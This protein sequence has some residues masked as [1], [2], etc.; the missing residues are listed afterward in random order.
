MRRLAWTRQWAFAVV[1]AITG[2]AGTACAAGAAPGQPD[3]VVAEASRVADRAGHA[4]AFIP[5]YDDSEL[6]AVACTSRANCMVVGG[7]SAPAGAV[8]FAKRWNGRAWIQLSTPSQPIDYYG[9][10]SPLASVSCPS[11]SFCQAVGE[12]GAEGW[13]GRAWLRERTATSYRG[14]E[15][16]SVSCASATSCV[17][18]GLRSGRTAGL[19]TFAETWD[20]RSWTV[21]DPANP[22]G[23]RDDMLNSV[24]CAS[25]SD[26]VAVGQ[27]GAPRTLAEYWNGRTWRLLAIPTVAATET[28][29]SA[30]SCSSATSCLAVGRAGLHGLAESWNGSRWRLLPQPSGSPA[31]VS[32][33]AATS[34]V[35]VGATGT[36]TTA[37][38]AWNGSSWRPLPMPRFSG[39]LAGVSCVSS[40]SCMAAGSVLPGPSRTGEGEPVGD[41]VQDGVGEL[42]MRWDGQSWRALFVDPADSLRGVSCLG[43][44]QCVAV[45][46]YLTRSVTAAT[47]SAWWN[48]SSWRRQA[49][50]A[51]APGSLADVSCTSADRCVAVGSGGEP[52]V[53]RFALAEQW[54]GRS[55]RAAPMASLGR[56][57]SESAVSC[58]GTSCLAV[59]DGLLTELWN[60]ARWKVVTARRPPHFAAGDL[61]D[62]SCASTTFCMATGWFYPGAEADPAPFAESWNGTR[63]TLLSAPAVM[64]GAVSC[65]SASFCMAAGGQAVATW[66]GSAWQASTLPG[67]FGAGAHVTGVSCPSTSA[68]MVVGYYLIKNSS[69]FVVSAANLAEFWNGSAWRILSVAGPGGGLADVSCASPASCMA[70]GVVGAGQ[71]GTHTLAEDWTGGAG[72]HVLATPNP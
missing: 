37:A 8:A 31:A 66:N 67:S 69:N 7:R 51:A 12:V 63:W 55:W 57:G 15:L 11:A 34:C 46:G 21:H 2:V 18:V 48:G 30:I 61:T 3:R 40:T 72:F 22:A 52:G 68:C 50:P 1:V 64:Y 17:A 32:C 38:Q 14:P 25:A 49:A 16:N 70:V 10:P 35:V 9:A 27:S 6:S 53:P 56:Y 23:S 59:G 45:G 24:S 33:T 65:L 44:S 71:V 58:A 47:L 60:G 28:W 43:A 54:N 13:N 29:L 41:V 36:D 4:T 26:C 62:V 39:P 20:G 5:G 19:L 42:A